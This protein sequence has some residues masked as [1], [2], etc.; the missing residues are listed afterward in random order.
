MFEAAL[1][2][3]HSS[4]LGQIPAVPGARAG[5][6]TQNRDPRVSW[7]ASVT[8]VCVDDLGTGEVTKRRALIL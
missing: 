7:V 8:S 5:R 6:A 2:L 4:K 1:S 3:L